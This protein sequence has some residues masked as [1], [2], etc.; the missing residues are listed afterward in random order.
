[1]TPTP[2]PSG[3]E[4]A[5]QYVANTYTRPAFTLTHGQGMT[6]WD[7]DGKAYL[8]FVAGIA[9]MAFG[10][11]D[12]AIAAIIQTHASQLIH[13][14]NLYYTEPQAQLAAY[15]CENSFA[16]R[17]FF[18][19]SGAEANEA[20]L[21]F[22]RKYAYAQGKTDKTEIIAFDHA[23]HG[24]TMGT[25]SVTP[26]AAY[27]D[28]FRPLLPNTTILP[29]NDIAAAKSAITDKTSAVIL[30]P[31][32]GEGGIHAATPEFLQTLRDLCDRH[33]A[34]LIFDEVQ[35]GLGRTGTLWAHEA[36]GVTPDM[37]TLAKPL[38]AGLPI[39]AA[40]INNRVHQYLVPGDHGSTFGGGAL[41]C[42]VAQAVIKRINTTEFLSHVKEMGHYF[43]E[44]LS[45]LNA[46][47]I[48]EIRG[49]GLMLG[50]ELTTPAPDMIKAGYEA[51]FLL[52]NA[53][54]NTIRLVPPLIVE[55]EHINA[56]LTFLNS[57]FSSESL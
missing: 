9:V 12:P 33:D 30:E 1:M 15:L 31:V 44:R 43:A 36:S 53:G 24:R 10:H 40:L 38:A 16:D 13:V 32:Q 23:F 56:L 18:A 25:L 22:A 42:S 20:C 41:V 45:E 21:K 49:R 8:D 52:V 2:N 14:S 7:S 39:G 4:L 11:S 48:K 27:Q 50:I 29:F 17:V 55:Q 51:G 47:Q 5:K 46:P 35:C 19:N 3:A 37:M 6:V 26:K 28:P 34:L 54:P 57:Y